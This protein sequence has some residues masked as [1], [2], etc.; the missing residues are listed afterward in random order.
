MCVCVCEVDRWD[1]D[2]GEGR[3][4]FLETTEGWK[5]VKVEVSI[6]MKLFNEEI[7]TADKELPHS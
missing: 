1:C 3:G 5:R 6:T 4:V 7:G 2:I